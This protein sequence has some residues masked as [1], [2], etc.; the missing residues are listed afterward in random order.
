MR[1]RR[2]IVPVLLS[3]S[4][5]LPVA[6][7][8]TLTETAAPTA[9]P[10]SAD[11]IL[12]WEATALRTV[13]AENAQPIPV[14]ILYLGFTSVAM[15]E[16]VVKARH[17]DASKEA[18]AAVA[19][20][21][22]LAEYFPTSA[23]NLTAD[24]EASLSGIPDGTAK[25]RGMV[26]GAK[27]AAR[28]ID[29]RADDGRGNP[30]YVYERDEKPGVW[31]PTTMPFLA[32]WLGFVDPLE[33]HRRVRLDGPDPIWSRAYA[34]D[35]QEVKRVGI[36]GATPHRTDE[37]ALTAT[38]FNTNPPVMY[39]NALI[40]ALGDD[41]MSLRATSLLFARMHAAMTDTIIQCWWQKFR[42]GFWRPFQAIQGADDDHNPATVA[43]PT[44]AP[45]IPN[46]PYPD[47]TSGHACVTS[48]SM[49]VIRRTLGETTEL[50]LD[51]ANSDIDRTYTTLSELEFEA[52]HARIWGGLHFRD[53]MED[54][55]YLGHEIARRVM[56]ELR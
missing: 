4:L 47:Y 46:P 19:A 2:L 28:M 27:A 34:F 42:V 39:G 36:A 12:D 3:L 37:Q 54:G 53:A 6:P 5:L 48:S 20:H 55:Y 7:G 15:Y 29:D 18:A 17:H 40:D 33:V 52:F 30:K 35:F 44:W 49:E 11:V 10:A 21:D 41:P 51:S 26:I 9:A 14:G 38:F 32:P 8:S 16:A 56:R 31:Q 1:R 24:L 25:E 13:Y 43:D 50:T 22:V 45:F 23:P